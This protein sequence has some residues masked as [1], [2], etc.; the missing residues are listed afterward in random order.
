MRVRSPRP[1][2]RFALDRTASPVP[3][4]MEDVGPWTA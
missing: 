2:G 1:E 4:K 3:V